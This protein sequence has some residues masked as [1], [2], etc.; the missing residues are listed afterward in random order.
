MKCTV[1]SVVVV[2]I[3]RSDFWFNC[4]EILENFERCCERKL[5]ATP[6]KIQCLS[7]AMLYA[8]EICLIA[9]TFLLQNYYDL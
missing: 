1:V 6:Y 2:D 9:L 8:T 5:F 4:D 3:Y 7:L